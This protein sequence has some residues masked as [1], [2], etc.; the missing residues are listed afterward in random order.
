TFTSANFSTPQT[1][2]VTGANDGQ[3]GNV[4][5]T[6]DFAPAVSADAN[7]NGLHPSSNVSLT[8]LPAL[9]RSLQVENL[10]LQPPTGLHDGLTLTLLW[11]DANRGNLQADGAWDDQIVI[12]NT[13]TGVTL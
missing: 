1:V 2:T 13:T 12:K 7:Y 10:T 5:Y 8:N 3:A 6:I 11:N 4:A 9:A